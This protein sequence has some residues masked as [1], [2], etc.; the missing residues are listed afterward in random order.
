[1]ERTVRRASELH[2]VRC[3]IHLAADCGGILY[4]SQNPYR[5]W[6]RNL[7]M[8]INVLELASEIGAALVMVGTVCSYPRLCSVPFHEDAIWDG[9]PES[10]NAPYGIA[11]RALLA[12]LLAARANSH[13]NYGAYLI[14]ANL[15]GH[16]GEQGLRAHVIPDIFLK[17][18]LA[19]RRGEPVDLMGDGTATR[20]F[21]WVDDAAE[22]IAMAAVLSIEEWRSSRW[23]RRVPVLN[24]GT[25]VETSIATLA[26][27]VQDA[28][29]V[30]VP[31]RWHPELPGGQ[32]RRA[33]DTT[34][35]KEVLGW[36]AKMTLSRGL[37]RLAEGYSSGS[38]STASQGTRAGSAPPCGE[39]A[40][41]PTTPRKA[42]RGRRSPGT[43]SRKR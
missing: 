35:A 22:A 9:Y 14:L 36:E 18:L 5:L 42:G 37:E 39:G 33:L 16:G 38:R 3:I 6:H 24:I 12:G 4:N 43:S 29:G 31:I 15:Y 19:H 27:M 17:T 13:I 8:G 26:K 2:D 28:L 21:L 10:T 11:K 25:G 40:S 32:P 41:T 34:R 1:V 30:N 20:D 23:P 7:L